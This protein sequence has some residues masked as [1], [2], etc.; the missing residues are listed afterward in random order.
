MKRETYAL[1]TFLLGLKFWHI[2]E[3]I[4]LSIPKHS[5]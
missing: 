2:N 1:L 3:Y 5:M 4:V